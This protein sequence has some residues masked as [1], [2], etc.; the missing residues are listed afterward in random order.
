MPT[1]LCKGKIIFS[2]NARASSNFGLA[3][4]F[5]VVV[6]LFVVAVVVVECLFV[7]YVLCLF[8]V[9]NKP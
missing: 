9:V 4:L 1:F 5:I 7:L 6:C 3:A 8:S 2:R